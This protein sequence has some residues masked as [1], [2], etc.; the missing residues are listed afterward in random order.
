[1]LGFLIGGFG[2]LKRKQNNTHQEKMAVENNAS[3]LK[4]QEASDATKLE[5]AKLEA[6]LKKA[7]LKN[8][9][10]IAKLQAESMS[11][12]KVNDLRQYAGSREYAN[13]SRRGRGSRPWA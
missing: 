2:A 6:D 8:E 3:A 9:L 10:E 1:M 5:L 12:N 4:L 7:E 13:S 11:K